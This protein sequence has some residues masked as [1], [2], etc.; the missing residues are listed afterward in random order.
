MSV[1]VNDG[2]ERIEAE[3]LDWTIRVQCP[4]FTDW[5]SLTDWLN[6]DPRHADSFNRLSLRE[7]EAV[8]I[9]R[10]MPTP[11]EPPGQFVEQGERIVP[12]R[13][14]YQA[15]GF[16]PWGRMAAGFVL[17]AA[18]AAGLF[19]F[20]RFEKPRNEARPTSLVVET[21]AGEQR[22]INLADGTQIALG[23]ATRLSI[24]AKERHASLDRGRALFSVHHN[25]ARP[26]SVGM[27]AATI[28][29]VGTIF[30]LR[31]DEEGL[32]VN[33]GQGEVR[34]DQGVRSIALPAGHA[35]HGGPE[36][37]WRVRSIDPT[38]VGS[39]RHGRFNYANATIADVVADIQSVTGGS[40]H[41]SPAVAHKQFA[42][43]IHIGSD[44]GQTLSAV[45]PI[46]GV[47][48]QRE[49]GAWVVESPPNAGRR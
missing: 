43:S 1:S 16:N 19:T 6:A 22:I 20:E 37:V 40:I 34:V 28:T 48:I 26:F 9:V 4:D 46:L 24:D 11:T 8:E 17:V 39:W 21:Q 12:L 38:T 33:V 7:D 44:A 30:D 5:D 36:A 13:Q 3:A 29:D 2:R 41:L 10:K 27:G 18:T 14:S 42:G 35:L 49:G 25:P 32:D 15:R 45:A 23:G 31:R 47:T